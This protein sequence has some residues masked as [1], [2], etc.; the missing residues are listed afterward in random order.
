M[1]EEF[2]NK[3]ETTIMGYLAGVITLEEYQSQMEVIYQKF[4]G[5]N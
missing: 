2:I 4:G 3:M 5:V 1:T